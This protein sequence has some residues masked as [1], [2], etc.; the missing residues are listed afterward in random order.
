MYVLA[1]WMYP[2]RLTDWALD[3]NL[4]FFSPCE[5]LSM[6][7]SNIAETAQWRNTS[8]EYCASRPWMSPAFLRHEYDFRQKHQ[9]IIR[10]NPYLYNKRAHQSHCIHTT[11]HTQRSLSLRTHPRIYILLTLFPL[12]AHQEL[13]NTELQVRDFLIFLFLGRRRR[14]S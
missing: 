9:L 3:N 12:L 14:R 7:T 4:Q 8:L 1:V 10:T 13:S 11:P 2:V 5:R 6:L